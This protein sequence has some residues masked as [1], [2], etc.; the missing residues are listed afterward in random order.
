MQDQLT[1]DL[2]DYFDLNAPGA[3][4]KRAEGLATRLI[5]SALELA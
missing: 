3:I 4:E 1:A 2:L 5:R